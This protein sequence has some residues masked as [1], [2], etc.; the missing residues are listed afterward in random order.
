MVR[1]ADDLV[2]GFEHRGDAQL[3][4]KQFGERL[5]KFG[6]EL[7]PEK[8][9]LLEF[10]RFAAENRR[11]RGEKKPETF[12]F[13]GFVHYRGTSLKGRFMVWRETASKRMVAKLKQIKLTLRRRMHEPLPQM[14]AWLRRVLQGFYRYHAVPGKL[15]AMNVFRHRLERL[16]RSVLRHRSQRARSGWRCIAQ[17]FGSLASYAARSASLSSVWV[18]R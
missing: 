9:R 15:R 13:L 17:L 5:A 1:Y 2:V 10:G 11:Q 7:H 12:T 14:G 3:F 18:R 4:L 6:L 16:W 8:T